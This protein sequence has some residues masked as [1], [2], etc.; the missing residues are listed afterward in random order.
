[1]STINDI[2][3]ISKI[4][5]GE[6]QVFREKIA[7]KPFL[8]YYFDFFSPQTS[9]KG[10]QLHLAQCKE[11]PETI[12]TD[13]SKL[14]SILTNLIKNAIKFTGNGRIEFGC[15]NN[16]KC[17][18]LFYVKDTGRGIEP[19]KINMIFERFRQA[20]ISLTRG[21]EGSGLGLSISK[22]Y[23]EA[24]GGKIWVES[25]PGKGSCFCFTI[26]VTDSETEASTPDKTKEPEEWTGQL[27]AKLNILIAEDD[28]SS[29]LYLETIL[30]PFKFSISRCL[31]GKEAVAFC[32]KHPET[33]LILMDIKM[34]DMDGCAATRQIREFN[35]HVTIIAQTAFALS[36]DEKKAF[37]AGCNDYIS[38]PFTKNKFLAL[39]K[40]HSP[41]KE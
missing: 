7:L 14:D 26:P 32:R 41:G 38:K 8:S 1:L 16:N 20:D 19:D 25:E 40:K 33:N 37:D 30:K 27:P 34:P 13:K 23:V 28:D 2:I 24:L 36:G 11:A 21:Y 31:S 22:A 3:E 18:L 15:N 35:S 29:F 10:L 6:V 5:T 12:F 17:D 4:E 9:E 39:I